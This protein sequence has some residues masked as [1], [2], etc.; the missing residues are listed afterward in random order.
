MKHVAVPLDPYFRE[1][2]GYVKPIIKK[3]K[4]KKKQQKIK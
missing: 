2:D 4:N 3:A 1:K